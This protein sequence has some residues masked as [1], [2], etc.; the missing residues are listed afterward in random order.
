MTFFTYENIIEPMM[1]YYKDF[2]YV[3]YILNLTFYHGFKLYLKGINTIKQNQEKEIKNN[4][5]KV[6]LVEI[7][8]GYKG[9]FET[10]YKS[11]VSLSENKILEKSFKESEEKR[12]ISEIEGRKEVKMKERSI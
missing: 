10:Y 8:N 12:I 3:N 11:K 5:M 4:V 1:S 9:D 7:Q 6:W 2:N